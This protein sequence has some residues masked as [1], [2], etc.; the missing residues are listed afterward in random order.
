MKLLIDAITFD[1]NGS[2]ELEALQESNFST[3]GRRANKVATLDGGVAINDFGF[4]HADR[5]FQILLRPTPEQDSALRYIVEN[6]GQVYVSTGEGF[7]KAIP[8]YSPGPSQ[9]TLSLSVT[10]KIA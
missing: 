3:L 5:D 2:V 9:S 1:L 6:Y 10:E 4:T 8:E 7:F